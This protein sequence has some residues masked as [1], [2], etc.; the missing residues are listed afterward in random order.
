MCCSIPVS[1]SAL[2]SEHMT[3]FLSGKLKRFLRQ[4]LFCLRVVRRRF[5]RE[6]SAGLQA[7]KSAGENR[8]NF[9]EAIVG[10]RI[11]TAH[12]QLLHKWN[13]SAFA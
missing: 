5:G 9:G 6:I 4:I 3:P 12:G 13:G 8:G 10:R 11:V 1:Q 7:E 2:T